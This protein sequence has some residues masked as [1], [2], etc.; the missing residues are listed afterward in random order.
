MNQ[1]RNPYETR[2]SNPS[3]ANGEPRTWLNLWR[4]F[5]IV[6]GFALP[7]VNTVGVV[8]I[9]FASL[10]VPPWVFWSLITLPIIGFLFTGTVAYL[11]PKFSLLGWIAFGVNIVVFLFESLLLIA[12]Y[13]LL[14]TVL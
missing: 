2:G 10:K 1:S 11:S 12:A 4:E 7:V 8:L 13:S 14:R 9:V 5:S 3:E 6:F